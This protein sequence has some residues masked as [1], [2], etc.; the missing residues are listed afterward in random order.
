MNRR[1]GKFVRP[2]PHENTEKEKYENE[3]ENGNGKNRW[4]CKRLGS[5]SL[6]T[7]GNLNFYRP[8]GPMTIQGAE[9]CPQLAEDD[10]LPAAVARR[11]LA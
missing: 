5:I 8:V 9:S 3:N 6:H 10:L 4:Y 1:K 11:H 2:E 7:V